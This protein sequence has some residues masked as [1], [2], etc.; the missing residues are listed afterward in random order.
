MV[1]IHGGDFLEGSGNDPMFDGSKVAGRGQVIL[2]TL[3]YRLGIFGFLPSVGWDQWKVNG[4]MNGFMDIVEALTWINRNIIKWGGNPDKVTVFGPS[5]TPAV[6]L[7]TMCPL[8]KGKF[9][10]AI[11][12]TSTRETEVREGRIVTN[13]GANGASCLLSSQEPYQPL[14]GRIEVAYKFFD[15]INETYYN[16]PQN[17]DPTR[18]DI[19]DWLGAFALNSTELL[20]AT[21]AEGTVF[22]PSRPG[23]SFDYNRSGSY[24]DTQQRRT[25]MTWDND[26]FPQMPIDLELVNPIDIMVGVRGRATDD[27]VQPLASGNNGNEITPFGYEK[28]TDTLKTL[29]SNEESD[30]DNIF[31]HNPDGYDRNLQENDNDDDY[32]DFYATYYD[33]NMIQDKKVNQTILCT[34]YSRLGAMEKARRNDTY[35]NPIVCQDREFDF[36]GTTSD[37]EL[38]VSKQF[39]EILARNVQGNVYGYVIDDG[40][41]LHGYHRRNLAEGGQKLNQE[42]WGRSKN[43]VR[44]SGF[45]YDLETIYFFDNYWYGNNVGWRKKEVKIRKE[46]FNRWI[47][48]AKTGVPV[49]TKRSAAKARRYATWN[50]FPKGEIGLDT[51]R[52]ITNTDSYTPSYLYMSAGREGEKGFKLK[53][54]RMVT[55]EDLISHRTHWK[56]DETK[57]DDICSWVLDEENDYDGDFVDVLLDFNANMA[58]DYYVTIPATLNPT[59]NYVPDRIYEVKMPPTMAPTSLDN[60]VEQSLEL[61]MSSS[62]PTISR[63]IKL[64][65]GVASI[66]IADFVVFG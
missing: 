14:E 3:N 53:K 27:R 39:A 33:N 9:Q 60:F 61:E 49:V 47:N 65:F 16:F 30:S 7:L 50:A 5:S 32:F 37:Q 20:N 42:H 45:Y 59:I 13:N 26:I 19:I 11:L 51:N 36:S 63:P 46:L 55:L 10:R 25:F 12:Q 35:E 56:Y 1:Y 15:Y 34:D 8:A 64:L 24:T 28:K 44:P 21:V 43:Q 62:P 41:D 2:I 48:F 38:C 29:S 31:L 57:N 54:S 52:L 6:C 17:P 4:G 22:R 18:E 58:F 40:T 23:S 66:L